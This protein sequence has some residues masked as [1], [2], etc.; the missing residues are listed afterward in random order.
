MDKK[1][2]LLYV[3]PKNYNYYEYINNYDDIQF[4][5]KIEAKYHYLRLG[6][7]QKRICDTKKLTLFN[8]EIYKNLYN[9]VKHLNDEDLLLHYI[10]YGKY[11]KRLISESELQLPTNFN[12][13]NYRYANL[14]LTDLNDTQVKIHCHRNYNNKPFIDNIKKIMDFD[15]DFYINFY[16]DVSSYNREES[17]LHFI[18]FGLIECRNYNINELNIP[19]FSIYAY[20]VLYPELKD[21]SLTKIKIHYYKFN[22]NQSIEFKSDQI[23]NQISTLNNLITNLNMQLSNMSSIKTNEQ[24]QIFGPQEQKQIQPRYELIKHLNLD[25]KNN[26]SLIVNDVNNISHIINDVNKQSSIE[27]T[28]NISQILTTEPDDNYIALDNCINDLISKMKSLISQFK[29]NLV[30]NVT[31]LTSH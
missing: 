26:I 15:H 6:R 1:R 24:I 30:D 17:L 9:D 25:D 12:I 18:K 13:A 8:T 27:N 16:D 23:S 28:N 14:G 11:E 5:T 2:Y 20:T 10:R 7:Y 3:L 19:P 4:M 29:I 31:S 21:S 22:M